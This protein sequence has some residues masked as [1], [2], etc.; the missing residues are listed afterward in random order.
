M[1]CYPQRCKVCGKPNELDFTVTDLAWE[2]IVPIPY[3]NKVVCLTCFDSFASNR[4]VDYA[5]FLDS[6]IH[7]V[8]SAAMFRL[9]VKSRTSANFY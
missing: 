5:D 8:G 7:F 9:E 2:R 1:D 4:G 3:R 6:E